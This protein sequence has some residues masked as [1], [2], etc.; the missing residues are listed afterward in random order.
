MRRIRVIAF[1]L[2]VAAVVGSVTTT[3][4]GAALPHGP[5]RPLL[6]AVVAAGSPGAL[7]LVD[8]GPRREAATGLAV[9]QGR[10]PLRAGDRFRAGSITKTFVAV[11]V[12]QLVAEDR[13]QAR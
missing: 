6:D 2:V 12:L 1:A 5:P 7:V 10:V 9:L 11:V 4:G 13:L 8:D 3:A